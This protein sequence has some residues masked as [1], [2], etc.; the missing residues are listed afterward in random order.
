VRNPLDALYKGCEAALRHLIRT[1][2][3]DE[4]IG[5]TSDPKVVSDN[6]IIHEIKL[7]V[8]LNEGCRAFTLSHVSVLDRQ[9]HTKLMGIREERIVQERVSERE[10]EARRQKQKVALEQ[11][12]LVSKE[13]EIIELQAQIEKNRQQILF[14]A[15]QLDVELERLRKLP[16]FQHEE[17]LKDIDA[18]SKAIESLIQAQAM[19][20]FPRNA[21]DL[22]LVD[23]IV[24]GLPNI[25]RVLD[26]AAPEQTEEAKELSSTLVQLIIPKKR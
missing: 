17:I 21:D 4:L 23:K 7:Q 22:H 1:H 16:Q 12:E 2:K 14:V 25:P 15:R 18:R 19:P 9:G 8:S 6:D 13:G 10:T 24:N 5:E 26:Q 11:K 3:H 20:G